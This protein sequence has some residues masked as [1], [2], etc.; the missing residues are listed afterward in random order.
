M[1]R[2]KTELA[3]R[4]PPPPYTRW[5]QRG[6]PVLLSYLMLIDG[7]RLCLSLKTE[8]P[9]IAKRHMRLLVAMLL[10]ERRLSPDNGAAEVYG[11]KGTRRARLDDV[12][13]EVRRLKALSEAEYGPE[14]L[15]TAK[16][17]GRP[18]G[19]IHHLAGRKPGLSAGTYA[20]RRMRARIRGQR[21]PMGDTWE[22]RP[23]GGKYF[24][25]NGKVLTARLQIGGRP[26]QWPLKGIDEKKAGTL[27]KPVRVARERLRQAAVEEL[28]CEL[29]T[30]AAADA[31]VVRAGA[32][33]QLARAIITAG[34]PGKLAEFVM[35]GPHEEVG[36]AVPQRAFA[37]TAAPSA[38][39]SATRRRQT[40]EKECEQLLI[41]RYQAYLRDGCKE[42]PLK[43]ELRAEMT[44]LIPKLSGRA[45]D[46]S[47]K[48]T[49]VAKDWDW[50]D[51]G[52]RG[53]EKPPQKTPSKNPLKK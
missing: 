49:A 46:R 4:C 41:E 16:R 31:A 12:K 29:G 33:A 30:I 53:Q 52:F 23:Q 44:G 37:L 28:N 3:Q 9:D 38:T 18:V 36:M 13:T 25:W 7:K 20:T 22:H 50:K 6:K 48:G 1:A 8:D 2:P 47:W 5:D 11:P 42:R 43:D 32:R 27:M 26:W 17:W 40:A 19:I 45:F 21:M 14:A 35:K 39:L 51:P 10:V 15:A 34:G 24:G